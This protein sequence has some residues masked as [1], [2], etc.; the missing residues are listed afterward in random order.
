[1]TKRKRYTEPTPE[2]PIMV[3]ELVDLPDPPRCRGG[4]IVPTEGR[5]PI[6]PVPADEIMPEM[7]SYRDANGA[8]VS[9]PIPDPEK[10]VQISEDGYLLSKVIPADKITR[11]IDWRA[12][13]ITPLTIQKSASLQFDWNADRSMNN[14]D[15]RERPDPNDLESMDRFYVTELCHPYNP[16]PDNKDVFVFYSDIA[17]L[18]GTAGYIR[19]RDGYVWGQL[20]VWRS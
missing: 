7:I 9:G 6:W 13:G 19:L 2:H 14:V 3:S 15:N 8:L 18:S 20:A 1:M 10:G 12:L 4:E 11:I 17:A 16:K 5:E